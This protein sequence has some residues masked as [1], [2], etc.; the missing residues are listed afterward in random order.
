[1]FLQAVDPLL[2][3]WPN[4]RVWFIGD[5]PERGR[6]YERIR[7]MDGARQIALPGCFDCV[8]DIFQLADVC[9]LT[10]PGEGLGFFAPL[11]WENNI[12]CLL[13]ACGSS[14]ERVPEMAKWGLFQ[15]GN[16]PQLRELLGRALEMTT[17]ATVRKQ[18]TLEVDDTGH[19]WYLERWDAWARFGHNRS[20]PSGSSVTPQKEPVWKRWTS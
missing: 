10:T 18:R 11:A 3:R 12:P 2:D 5:G 14:K 19:G 6:I 16:M 15:A 4:L 9:M 20:A 8:D 7:D 13:P 17:D 1:M